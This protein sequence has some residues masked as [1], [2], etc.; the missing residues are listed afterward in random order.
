MY[1]ESCTNTISIFGPKNASFRTTSVISAAAILMQTSLT[2]G[3]ETTSSGSGLPVVGIG[4]AATAT[5]SQ[6]RGVTLADAIAGLDVLEK[7]QKERVYQQQ[8]MHSN[9]PVLNPQTSLL[10]RYEDPYEFGPDDYS[11]SMLDSWE[12]PSDSS[13]PTPPIPGPHSRPT[14]SAVKSVV[15]SHNSSASVTTVNTTTNLITTGLSSAV[16]SRYRDNGLVTTMT[17]PAKPPFVSPFDYQV[18]DVYLGWICCSVLY[19]SFDSLAC[20][21]AFRPP[22]VSLLP[23]LDRVCL[24]PG[25]YMSVSFV[26]SCLRMLH[27]YFPAP[28]LVPLS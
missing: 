17:P 26:S 18:C 1:A 19:L 24:G 20:A 3:N 8:R 9:R 6:P 28:P 23:F 11:S 15:L 5:N 22:F 25:P 12:P 7:M 27:V 16:G 14:G 21:H 4:V 13:S 10:T 2:N